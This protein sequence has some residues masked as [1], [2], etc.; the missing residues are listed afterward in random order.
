MIYSST[1]RLSLLE[2]LVNLVGPILVTAATLWAV[3]ATT[4]IPADLNLLVLAA[5][6]GAS[7]VFCIAVHETGHL[8]VGLL[9]HQP[10]RKILI[11][12]GRTIFTA[13]PRGLRVQVCANL[14]GGGAVYFSAVDDTRAE[15]RIAV[16]A[17]G[18]VVNLVLGWTALAMLS[19]GWPWLGTLALSNLMLGAANLIPSRFTS[20]GRQHVSDGMQ[21]LRMARGD[22]LTSTFFE[23]EELSSDGQKATI[24]SIE[25]A[26]DSQSEQLTEA[27]LL[28]SLDRDPEIHRL[29]ASASFADLTSSAGPR[30]SIDVRP[31]RSAIVT[32]VYKVTFRIARDLGVVRPNAPCLC[33]GLMAVPSEVATRLHA[34]GV[35]E[36]ALRE[37]AVRRAEPV[38]STRPGGALLADLPLERWGSAADRVLALALRIATVD[39]SEDT[40]TQHLLAA[41]VAERGCR[42]AQ[43]L[44]RTGFVLQRNERAVKPGDPPPTPPPLTPEVQSAIAAALL[45]TGPTYPCGTGE[46]CLGVADQSRSMAALLFLT[47]RVSTSALQDA[48]VAVPR[49]QSDPTGYTPSMRRMWE[50]RASARLGAGRYAESRADFLQLE[51]TAPTEAV[52]AINHNNVAWVSLMSGNP[53]LVPEALA[54]SRA[55][56]AIDPEQRSF[57][58]TYAFALLETGDTAGAAE[59]LETLVVDHPRPRDRA[60][61]LCLLAMSRARLHDQATARMRLS[62]AEEVDPRCALL[63]RA[64]AEVAE[65]PAP[66]VQV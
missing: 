57:Q 23:G 14:L 63:E 7:L 12:S 42:A 62:E 34:G 13:R 6:V 46:L 11:G 36:T 43:A 31:V 65:I 55:A 22:P 3:F 15:A 30:S 10:I 25:E 53:V 44:S 1:H 59:V 16:T 20:G 17:A 5:W 54:R 40:G 37:L 4:L 28:A 66:A 48:V 58:G 41:M 45:R 49:E 33:L 64:R 21:I 9:V 27:H 47:G 61:A 56:L 26:L 8:V 60:L 29:L 51:Q 50:L 24:G 32:Q 19:T 52:R 2:S 39:H 38:E 18:P 35:S